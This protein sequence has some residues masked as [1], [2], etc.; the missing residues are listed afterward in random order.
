VT[1]NLAAQID[2]FTAVSDSMRNRLSELGSDERAE[3]EQASRLLRRVRAG[4]RLPLTV[5]NSPSTQT[6]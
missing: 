3:V 1:A 6:G 4:R 5:H 2:A